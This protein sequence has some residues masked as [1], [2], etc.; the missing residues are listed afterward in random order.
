M[1]FSIHFEKKNTCYLELF[2]LSGFVQFS[3]F[4]RIFAFALNISIKKILCFVP[5]SFE[6]RV[7]LN[8]GSPRSQVNPSSQ[9]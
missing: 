3:F 2:F 7:G 5:I 8:P 9:A 4:T 1:G 6:N